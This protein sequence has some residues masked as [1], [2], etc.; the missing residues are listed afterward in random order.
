MTPMTRSPTGVLPIAGVPKFKLPSEFSPGLDRLS[1]IAVALLANGGE[2]ALKG[3]ELT[4]QGGEVARKVG[5]MGRKEGDKGC[6]S[7]CFLALDR[8]GG[9]AAAG[10]L[11]S[12]RAADMRGRGSS[13]GEVCGE[14]ASSTAV[15]L[16]R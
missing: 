1:S 15:S 5:D 8:V 14:N 6:W 9:S 11:F 10:Y 16:I 3:G 13:M 4:L 12:L 7:S 2:V